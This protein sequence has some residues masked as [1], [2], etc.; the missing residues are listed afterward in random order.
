PFPRLAALLRHDLAVLGVTPPHEKTGQCPVWQAALDALTALA[1]R[2]TFSR[3]EKFLPLL[4]EEE[5]DR[6]DF[7]FYAVD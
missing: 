6:A 3:I 5:G 2:G 1:Q 7:S 4:L